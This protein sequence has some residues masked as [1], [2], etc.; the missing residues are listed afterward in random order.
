MSF[1]AE[2]GTPNSLNNAYC[3]DCGEAMS[4]GNSLPVPT[5]NE[6]PVIATAT[7]VPSKQVISSLL[8]GRAVALSIVSLAIGIVITAKG[9]VEPIIGERFPESELEKETNS[10]H[11]LGYSIGYTKGET[12][13][14]SAGQ[15]E[16]YTKG[17][18][19]GCVD[20]F[21][22]LE[23]DDIIAIYYPYRRSN[24]GSTYYTKAEICN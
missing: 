7:S 22:S 5:P 4:L 12:D 14:Y 3:A 8:I 1:C 2:C 21:T 18:Y 24:I 11:E 15:S 23:S 20:V 10:A 16:G 6:R 13:G 19:D 9:V 17:F